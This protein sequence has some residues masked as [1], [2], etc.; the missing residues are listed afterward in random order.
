ML[1]GSASRSPPLTSSA[2]PWPCRQLKGAHARPERC[3]KPRR[4]A[5]QRQ[6]PE[7]ALW[8]NNSEVQARGL[9]IVHLS[10]GSVASPMADGLAVCRPPEAVYQQDPK[11]ASRSILLSQKRINGGPTQRSQS[12]AV[13][14]V[15]AP[16]RRRSRSACGF[17]LRDYRRDRLTDVKP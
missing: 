5:P 4:E 12:Q 7:R 13:P 6:L 9:S 11:K 10:S 1:R 3:H 16:V 8:T 17:R 15:R 14:S 2:T